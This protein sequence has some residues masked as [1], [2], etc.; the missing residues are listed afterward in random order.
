MTGTVVYPEK[1]NTAVFN[2][3]INLELCAHTFRE[4]K[5]FL[6]SDSL[7]ET[8]GYEKC[9]LRNVMYSRRRKRVN[10]LFHFFKKILSSYCKAA[11]RITGLF[12]SP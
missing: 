10:A 11:R 4:R 3:L 6:F 9:S 1:N 8:A 12:K 7:R 2:D 5:Q